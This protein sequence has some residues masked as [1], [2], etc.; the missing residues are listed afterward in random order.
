[1]NLT[2]A[3]CCM[4]LRR[5]FSPS[6]HIWALWQCLALRWIYN[7]TIHITSEAT[8][9]KFCLR[10]WFTDRQ[11]RPDESNMIAS[12]PGCTETDNFATTS[13]GD[14]PSS[15]LPSNLNMGRNMHPPCFS[16]HSFMGSSVRR[17]STGRCG[18]WCTKKHCRLG[19]RQGPDQL[20][21]L[22]QNHQECVKSFPV[23]Y[24]TCDKPHRIHS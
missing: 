6:Q 22:W 17:D 24:L 9:R 10:N 1:M 2:C 21:P 8:Y 12:A 23:F 15:S 4:S 13:A 16:P 20:K 18:P 7:K 11:E 19:R 14:P 5:L 3:C